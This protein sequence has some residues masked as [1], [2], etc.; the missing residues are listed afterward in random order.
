MPE[1]L[2]PGVYVEETSYR[3]KSIEGVGTS[4]AGFV[5][6]AR[7]GPTTGEPELLTSFADYERIYG[8]L[9]RLSYSGSEINNYLAHAV[10]AFFEEGGRRL[11][12][13]R[14]YEFD[15]SS[16]VAGK[17][18][19][20]ADGCAFATVKES[21]A[22]PSSKH[23]ILSA[24]HPGAAGNLPVTFAFR[25][26]PNLLR[27]DPVSATAV[28]RGASEYDLV[29][30]RPKSPSTA[31]ATLYWLKKT[32]GGFTFC[33]NSATERTL[34]E[35]LQ[36]VTGTAT[37]ATEADMPEMRILKVDV[38]AGRL[39]KLCQ[40]TRF[41]GLALHPDHPQ[42]LS[43]SFAETHVQRSTELFV[44]LTLHTALSNGVA[45]ANVL[46]AQD[47][48]A[49]DAGG[50]VLSVREALADST[51]AAD[52]WFQVRLANGSD[53]VRPTA[54]TYK[55]QES[56][57]ARSGL[58]AL[59]DLEDIAIVAAP[60]CTYAD[61]TG[62]YTTDALQVNSFLISHAERMRYR[63][64]VLDSVNGQILSDVKEHRARFDSSH[65]ALYYPWVRVMDPITRQEII[66]PP[67]GFITGI[68]A[69]NDVDHGV[70]KAPANEKIRSATG[71]EFNVNRAQQE[72][73]N[74]L[75]INCIRF[76]EGMGYVVWGA[77]TISSDPEW[78]YV[79]LRRYFA[80]LEHSIDA[81][82][83]WAVFMNNSEPLWAKTKQT[84]ED[85]L[86]NEWR[87]EHLM[88]T[89][90]E[91]AFFVRC[92]RST[93]TQN[94][95]DNGRLICLIGVAPVRPAEFVVF[96]IG[97]WTANKS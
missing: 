70:H 33:D 97:Q 28:L 29:W 89:K 83:G 42:S 57:G 65:A 67:S 10:R 38:I 86:Y 12:F 5:G 54:D 59:E 1:Y 6:P 91:E 61:G 19:N 22:D 60:G 18:S 34:A 48:Q 55:G 3:A 84:V 44:P 14:V 21:E 62:T 40:E 94:D 58:C 39:G 41:T 4:T 36:A 45:V 24:R 64:A 9:D 53:G 52:C 35:V 92:D 17:P 7:F 72:V 31:A 74:P 95:I 81:G 13:A 96:R 23:I 11:Y 93:M 73:L 76:F 47:S 63:I 78:K 77:R 80:Y 26:E 87:S 32:D 15:S 25:L 50:T 75:G 20:V 88:G 82:T 90:P 56:V 30:V 71:L 49:K 8:G 43:K 68:Y 69:R 46:L 66:L 2:A 79:N 27:R 85:F 16:S 37:P 51:A